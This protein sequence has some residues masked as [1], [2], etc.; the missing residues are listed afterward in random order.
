[1]KKSLFSGVAVLALAGVMTA[2]LPIGAARADTFNVFVGYADNLRPSGFFPTPFLGDPSV[3]SQTPTGQSYDTGAIRIQDT[4]A[5]PITITNFTVTF[6]VAPAASP[7]FNF[8]LPQTINPGQDAIFTQTFSYNFDTSDFGQFGGLPPPALYPTVPGNNEIGGCSSPASILG[9]S[10]FA[11]ACTASAPIISFDENGTPVSFTDS[12]HILNTGDWD[13]VNNG[14]FGS[15]G[16]ES[17]NWNIAG[18]E[19]NRGGTGVPEPATLSLLGLGLVGL[20]VLRRRK[21]D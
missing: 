18:S 14:T 1:M 10:G 7:S 15:D 5:T 16:N 4:G 8:W 20:G 17:I 3:V 2:G 13:F 6:P 21:A 12:G 11:A 9:P 19:A